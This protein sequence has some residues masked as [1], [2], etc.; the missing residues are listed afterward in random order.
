[1]PRRPR[2]GAGIRRFTCRVLQGPPYM[3][4]LT[5][6]YVGSYRVEGV[7]PQYN[8]NIAVQKVEQKRGGKLIL[9]LSSKVLSGRIGLGDGGELSKHSPTPKLDAHPSVLIFPLNA[10]RVHF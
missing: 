6:R 8:I 3:I 5:Q 2:E 4:G 1:M 9:N 7:G 10:L